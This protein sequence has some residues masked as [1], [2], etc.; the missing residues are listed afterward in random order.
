MT[1]SLPADLA[2]HSDGE[3]LILPLHLD[4]RETDSIVRRKSQVLAELRSRQ[5][6]EAGFYTTL[7]SSL[8]RE[9]QAAPWVTISIATTA[10]TRFSSPERISSGTFIGS[11]S[12]MAYR[13]NHPDALA[14]T[15]PR[16]R[17][18]SIY[19]DHL[20]ACAWELDAL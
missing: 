12:W 20:G 3:H 19:T 8:H 17:V 5:M 4:Q 16:I 7:P 1:S 18:L 14:K 11:Q 15:Q 13:A 10:S 9:L 6:N 2:I